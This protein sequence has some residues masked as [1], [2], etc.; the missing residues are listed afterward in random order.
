M[1]LRSRITGNQT[2]L[3]MKKVILKLAGVVVAACFMHGQ[4][5]V[6]FNNQSTFNPA[7]AITVSGWI[8]PPS[9]GIPGWGIGGDK[10][11]VQLLW[12]PGIVSSWDF[13][14]ANPTA[15]AAFGGGVFLANTGPLSS[16]SGFFDAGV[17]QMGGPAGVY[18]MQVLAWYDVGYPTYDSALAAG[19]SS[20]RSS[21][22]QANVTASPTPINSTVF[23]GF[24]LA[25]IPE[26]S[27]LA[28][29]GLGVVAMLFVRRRR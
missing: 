13:D 5:R 10:Y 11:A 12:L 16:F 21:L 29:A 6:A 19:V 27:V 2:P 3:R 1:A 14:A 17:V 8:N 20:G 15:S 26:P 18:T 23:P 22:F 9:G 28:L 4:G 24:T 7:D 25:L